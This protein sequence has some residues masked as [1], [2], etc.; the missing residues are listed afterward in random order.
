MT[1]TAISFA[2]V[3]GFIEKSRKLRDLFGASLIL[4]YLTFRLLEQAKQVLGEDCIISPGMPNI[5]EGMPNRILLRGYWPRDDVEKTLL[6]E[7][8]NVLEKCRATIEKH[9]A[10]PPTE[11]NWQSG[12]DCWSRYT[13]EIFWG[14]GKLPM[15]AMDNL[16]SR[17]LK[18]AWTA[19]NWVGESS[20]LTGTDAI[21]WPLMEESKRDRDE[22]GKP[23]NQQRKESIKQFY[24]QLAWVL[25]DSRK[26]RK[27]IVKSETKVEGKFLAEN[28]RLSVP[29][30]A[31]R[32][33]TLPSLARLIG[34]EQLDKSFSDINR[35]SGTWTG[36]FMGD[37]DNVGDYL[38]KLTSDVE[39]LAFSEAMRDW[40]KSFKADFSGDLGRVV[41]AGGDDFLGVIYNEQLKSEALA[42]RALQW[43]LGFKSE[44][45]KHKQPISVSMGFVWAGHQ[46]PQRDIL[47]HC[48][49]AEQRSKAQGKD[50]LTLRVVFNSGQ[51]VQ[52]TCPWNYLE[53]FL[54]AYQDREQKTWGQ[55]PNWVHLYQDWAHLQAR[56]S[57]QLKESADRA[58]DEIAL[59]LF[60]LYFGQRDLL[61]E[62][63]EEIIGDDQGSPAAI[64]KWLDGLINV[65]W[66]LCSSI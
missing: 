49:E 45:D 16:E 66:Q 22:L 28:E 12:W 17:K 20:S 15:E 52:W 57:V 40:G 8:K 33:V 26:R 10:P 53:Q 56:H 37:G 59:C 44:W 38:K 2:P 11:Y 63:A 13:W 5:Q 30:L 54:C 34:I 32:L 18:R 14:N 39:I 1:Y 23:L 64:L 43:L 21:A 50:R 65:G 55:S 25:D 6:M 41:Y 27:R 7:W 62:N 51:Y 19:I 48:R 24:R 29:E 36:W 46:V 47:Q 58:D 35:D 61:L 4:S 3:Q 9:F 60:D 31:K 42:N